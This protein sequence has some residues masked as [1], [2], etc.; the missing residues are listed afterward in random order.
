MGRASGYAVSPDERFEKYTSVLVQA[1]GHADRAGPLRLHCAGDHVL[2]KF[3]M[4]AA[5]G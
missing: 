2:V 3:P 5:A 4:S 1:V